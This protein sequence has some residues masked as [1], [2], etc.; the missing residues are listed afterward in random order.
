VCADFNPLA[1]VLILAAVVGSATRLAAI[2]GT[3]ATARIANSSCIDHIAVIVLVVELLLFLVVLLDTVV[4]HYVVADQKIVIVVEETQLSLS[5]GRHFRIGRWHRCHRLRGRMSV[6]PDRHRAAFAVETF[7]PKQQD[8]SDDATSTTSSAPRAFNEFRPLCKQASKHVTTHT[9]VL[10]LQHSL[11]LRSGVVSQANGSALLEVGG[12]KV[13]CA[14]HG[15]RSASRLDFSESAAL[16]CEF[17]YATFCSA[18]FEKQHMQDDEDRKL[19]L[20]L[21]QALAAAILLDRYP[22]SVIDVSILV[23]QDSGS[24]LAAAVT[25]AAVALAAAGIAMRDVVTC[26]SVAVIGAGSGA[27][28]RLALDPDDAT[29]RAADTSGVVTVAMMPALNEITLLDMHGDVDGDST[30]AS[31]ELCLDGCVGLREQVKAALL[32]QQQQH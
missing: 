30:V 12:T 32:T 18:S 21:Q 6:A 8:A 2:I 20:A 25:A 10:T 13:L 27:A 22:K 17:K 31:I 26:A 14:V 23:L 19:S 28:V 1:R 9:H 29:Q 24:A 7:A 15:P 11:V 3:G 16:Q 5:V 4:V